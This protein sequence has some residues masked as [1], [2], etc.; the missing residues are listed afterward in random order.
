MYAMEQQGA[1]FG[2]LDEAWKHLWSLRKKKKHLPRANFEEQGTD[3][4]WV[5]RVIT[6]P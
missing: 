6:I 1:I 4:I 3:R 2:Y 5:I